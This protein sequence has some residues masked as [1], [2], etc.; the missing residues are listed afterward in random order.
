MTEKDFS[1]SKD[2][3]PVQ[4]VYAIISKEYKEEK[5]S[6]LEKLDKGITL[7]NSFFSEDIECLLERKTLCSI[8]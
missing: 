8:I 2:G 6:V 4:K 7:E 5:Y 3:S 1:F